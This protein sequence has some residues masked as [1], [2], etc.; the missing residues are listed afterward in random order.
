VTVQRQHSVF[1]TLG[2][3]FLGAPRFTAALTLAIIGTLV[4]TLLITNLIGWAGLLG[5]LAALVILAALSLLAK[6]GEI[7]WH[8]LLPIS[9]LV[10]VAWAGASVFWSQYQWATLGSVVYFGAVTM[11]GIYVA[12]VRETIQI[13]RAF[14][15]VLRV[16]LGLSLALEIFSGILIDSPLP[17]LNVQG[18]I[19]ALGPIQGIFGT[20][21]LL[22]IVTLVAIITFGT[23]L[24]T[25]SVS[26]S[27]GIGSLILGG[28][29]LL[30]ARSPIA[31]GALFVVALAAVALYGLRRVTREHKR[32]WQIGLLAA[33]MT[34]AGLAWGF[35]TFIINFLS[36]SAELN[37]RLRLWKEIR[38]LIPE[39]NLQGWGWVGHWRQDVPPFQ[40]FLNF[41]SS[42]PTSGL[43]AY[44]DV[45]FQL[46]L[47]GLLLFVGLIGLTFVRSWLLASRQRSVVYAWPALVLVVL[48]TTALAESAILVDFGWL[49]F[50]VC[51]VKASR[52]L[53]WR[54][55]FAAI[56]RAPAEG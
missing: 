5:I 47:I 8:G 46:G 38:L 37:L 4:S 18:N 28:I 54:K 24:R 52:E 12:L 51:C 39:N 10:F 44:L 13:A 36:A 29:C 15:D 21:N 7:E 1:V 16:A 17:F 6:R 33:T 50:V 14:G 55:A 27:L 53:S 22:G 25:K 30:L 35:R 23:E 19:A 40:F 11:L 56:D 45:W 42:T 41:G 2:R 34:I 32:F 49:T 48:L 3:N 31:A 9:L 26:K 20:R 43:N